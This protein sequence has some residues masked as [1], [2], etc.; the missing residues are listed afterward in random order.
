MLIDGDSQGEWSHD[1]SRNR[2]QTHQWQT[3][4]LN[5][6]AKN[7]S[8]RIEI[9]ETGQDLSNG[10]GIRL[11]DI[12]IRRDTYQDNTDFEGAA[13]ETNSIGATFVDGYVDTV[14][15]WQSRTGA[16]ELKNSA[17]DQGQAISGMRSL[18]STRIRSIA[19]PIVPASTNSWRPSLVRTTHSRSATPAGPALMPALIASKC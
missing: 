4:R 13:W 12:K 15:G 18:S 16:I 6:T 19:S 9:L 17:D 10:R 14:N 2:S 5:F 11:D 1:Q 8:T 3:L 7:D